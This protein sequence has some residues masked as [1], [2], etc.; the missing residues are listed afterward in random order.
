MGLA[1]VTYVS[2]CRA[3]LLNRSRSVV[4]D[5]WMIDRT[6]RVGKTIK[7]NLSQGIFGLGRLS[8]EHSRSSCAEVGATICPNRYLSK[9]MFVLSTTAQT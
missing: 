2:Y 3:V 7:H 6:N 9:R 4:E 8:V 5:G 1:Q